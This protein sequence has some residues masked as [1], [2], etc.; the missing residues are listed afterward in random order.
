MRQRAHIS[1][2]QNVQIPRV[3]SI[4]DHLRATFAARAQPEFL[5]G[6]A[7]DFSRIVPPY[8]LTTIINRTAQVSRDFSYLIACAQLSLPFF[9]TILP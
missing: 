4:L 9:P 6:F 7:K 2:N 8:L 5:N 1:S 3:S